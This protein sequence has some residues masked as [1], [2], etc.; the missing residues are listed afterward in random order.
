MAVKLSDYFG[1]R[2][3]VNYIHTFGTTKETTYSDPYYY[4]TYKTEYGDNN[5]FFLKTGIITG[6]MRD[7]IDFIFFIYLGGGMSYTFPYEVSEHSLDY[8][9]KYVTYN[10][11][12]GDEMELGFTG[13]LRLGYRITKKYSLFIE[14]S[15]HWWSGETD[16]TINLNSGLTFHL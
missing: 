8:E 15:F 9:G 2:A 13:S 10:Y 11:D 4:N 16:R 6:S 1:F 14:P 3:D 7:D 5:I 12:R